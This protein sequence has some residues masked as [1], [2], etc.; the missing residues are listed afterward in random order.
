MSIWDDLDKQASTD[1]RIGNHDFVVDAINDGEWEPGRK[2]REL[3]G[4]L[5][6][7][8]N[9]NVK[10]RFNVTPDEDVVA[11]NMKT[12]PRNIVQSVNLSHQNDLVLEKEYGTSLDKVK[13]GDTFRVKTDYQTDK[14]DRTK[15]YIRI[16]NFLPKTASLSGNG[17][18]S[19]VPF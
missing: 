8:N 3:D 12:W 17:S 6:T 14:N 18:T 7:A 13:P 10:Q 9:F 1:D 19:D 5:T 15:K 16:V 11:A 4:R 2:Y